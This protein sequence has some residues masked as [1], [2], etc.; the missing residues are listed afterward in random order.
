MC[1]LL[2]WV[3]VYFCVWKGIKSAGKVALHFHDL[4]ISIPFFKLQSKLLI[5]TSSRRC[6]RTVST[7]IFKMLGPCLFFSFQV[8]YFTATFPYLV[9]FILLIRGA[10]LE[11]A[12]EGVIFY[13]K[14]DFTKLKNPQVI[15]PISFLILFLFSFSILLNIYWNITIA[16]SWLET[17]GL[18]QSPDSNHIF[19]YLYI[20]YQTVNVRVNE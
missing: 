15:W 16:G 7:Y 3:I 6:N 12:G 19:F 11:G 5:V 9:L 10:T 4:F 17:F 2:G 20:F 8:V 1:L 14:P 18:L 13:L